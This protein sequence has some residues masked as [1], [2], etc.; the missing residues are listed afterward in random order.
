MACSW[1]RARKWVCL[2]EGCS[3][4][5]RSEW[6]YEGSTSPGG[7][8]WEGPWGLLSVVT[9]VWLLALLAP[10]AVAI[11]MARPAD[12]GVLSE[13]YPRIWALSAVAA[14]LA[15]VEGGVLAHGRLL[16]GVPIAAAAGTVVLAACYITAF[17]QLRPNDSA[18]DDAA[19][20]GLVILGIPAFAVLAIVVGL[21]FVAARC[22]ARVHRGQAA[23]QH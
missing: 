23:G 11:S 4:G 21:G 7:A 2:S 14:A 18:S 1:R 9:A 10:A 12:G 20:A 16:W 15:L 3:R 6:D 19:G 22:G 5:C 8:S 17:V 13:V